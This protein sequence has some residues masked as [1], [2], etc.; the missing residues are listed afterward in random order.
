MGR[1][2]RSSTAQ[3]FSSFNGNQK[4]WK[5]ISSDLPAWWTKETGRCGDSLYLKQSCSPKLCP[6]LDNFYSFSRWGSTNQKSWRQVFVNYSE[7]WILSCQTVKFM[8]QKHD[9]FRQRT[10]PLFFLPGVVGY[11]CFH[12]V[13]VC[14]MKGSPHFLFSFQPRTD[15]VENC[16]HSQF[17]RPVGS[18]QSDGV[19]N[20]QWG[21][22]F[23]QAFSKCSWN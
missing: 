3:S 6:F 5:I 13:A 20:L 19:Q 16:K 21:G 18:A 9:F 2:L 11:V 8:K 12:Y 23:F 15:P 7:L 10:Y 14:N 22:V 4:D 17:G 1:S